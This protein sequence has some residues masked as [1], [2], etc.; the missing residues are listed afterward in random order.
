VTDECIHGFPT[1]LCDICSPRPAAVPEVKSAP[2]PRRIKTSLRSEQPVGAVPRP[3][4][5]TRSSASASDLPE[6]KV[7]SALRAHHFT[8]L[9]NLASI[10]DTET[11]LA[12][13]GAAP[14]LDVATPVAVEALEGVETPDGSTLADHVPF[15]LSPDGAAWNEVRSGA[16][17]DRWSDAARRARA[18]EFVVLVVPTPA[19]GQGA[20]VAD[21]DPTDPEVRFAVGPDAVTSLLRRAALTDPELH[22]A[23]LLAGPSVSF[24]SVAVI[25]VANDRTRNT[26]RELIAQAG[27]HAPRVAVFPPWF[28]P[29]PDEE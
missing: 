1:E 26:V 15:A 2:A 23:E 6:P 18:T 10:I 21:I 16:A 25:G 14:D 20:L 24:S 4:G 22:R 8:H 5:R 13:S 28:V 17:G 27:G 9:D 19:F 7:F 3:V 29:T 12:R 11:I